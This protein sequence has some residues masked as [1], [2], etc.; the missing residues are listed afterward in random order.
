MLAILGHARADP[1]SLPALRPALAAMMAA[2]R[3]EP[4]CLHYALAIED[5]GG[6]GQPA[7]IAISECWAD[8]AALEAHFRAPHMAEF[9]RSAGG[10]LRDLEV[11]LYRIAEELPF[12]SIPA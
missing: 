9:T 3:A 11:R 7:V 1:E 2:S 8:A 5:E 10:L 12:P 4:G 6:A